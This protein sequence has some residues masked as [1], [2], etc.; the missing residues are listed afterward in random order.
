MAGAEPRL[1]IRLHE[2]SGL[3]L[4]RRG[5]CG[6]AMSMSGSLRNEVGDPLSGKIDII[7][8]GPELTVT[9]HVIRDQG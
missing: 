9:S 8:E 7:E 2:L 3:G 4:C 1:S 5:N 6:R